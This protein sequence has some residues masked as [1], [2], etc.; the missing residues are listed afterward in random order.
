MVHPAGGLV[1][2]S[3][4]SR[5]EMRDVDDRKRRDRLVERLGRERQRLGRE[6][7]GR[8]GS[9]DWWPW[10]R[11]LDEYKGGDWSS[12]VLDLQEECKRSTENGE[13][14]LSAY[15][16]EEFVSIAKWAMPIIDEVEGHATRGG[17]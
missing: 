9:T 8:E 5:D 2:P 13:H 7:L 3:P 11:L 4:V 12:R 16:V 6:R 15:F 17:A 14:G 10:W 1:Y